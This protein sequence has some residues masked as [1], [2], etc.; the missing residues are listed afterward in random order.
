[1]TE[2]YDQSGDSSRHHRRQWWCRSQRFSFSLSLFRSTTSWL[3]AG[4]VLS[5]IASTWIQRCLQSVGH[6]RAPS[7]DCCLADWFYRRLLVVVDYCCGIV[8]QIAYVRV[9]YLLIRV[10]ASRR[11]C[12]TDI[13]LT[14]FPRLL[15]MKSLFSTSFGIRLSHLSLLTSRRSVDFNVNPLICNL[16]GRYACL[17][18][19]CPIIEQTASGCHFAWLQTLSCGCC[20]SVSDST[21]SPGGWVQVRMM[22]RNVFRQLA[23][24]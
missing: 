8:L 14:S 21:T 18:P 2:P 5:E 23:V 1:M 16:D 20:W 24:V 17:Q 15:L 12:Q 7:E 4:D 13:A 11:G 3:V 10:W 9:W 6:T 22:V 19:D